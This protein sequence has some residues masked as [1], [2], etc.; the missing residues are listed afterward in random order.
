[1]YLYARE[2]LGEC[3][4]TSKWARVGP[5][6]DPTGS[7]KE[8]CPLLR[9]IMTRRYIDWIDYVVRTGSPKDP[10]SKFKKF[11]RRRPRPGRTVDEQCAPATPPLGIKR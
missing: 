9:D 7:E 3:K 10:I 2:G 8:L 1:M 11:L 5:G 4:S 6:I